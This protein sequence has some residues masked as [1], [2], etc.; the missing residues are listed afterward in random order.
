MEIIEADS[1]GALEWNKFIRQHYPPIGGFMLTYEWGEFQK[2]LGRNIKRYLITNQK[3]ETMAAFTA[4]QHS[5][6]L[7]FSYG[8][9]PRGP[10]INKE[11]KNEQV[12]EILKSI[13]DFAKESMVEL[14]FLRLEPPLSFLPPKIEEAGFYLPNYY[15]QPRYNLAVKIDGS[16]E[17]I[18][19]TFHPSTRSNVHRA[20]NRGVTVKLKNSLSENDFQK[21]FL[22]IKETIKRNSGVNAYPSEKYFKSLM[23]AIVSGNASDSANN[24]SCGIF[25]GYQNEVPAGA[26]FVL[27][28]GETA[29]YLYGASFSNRL[30]SKVTTYL[31]FTAMKEA[32]KRGMKYYDLGGIDEKRWPTLTVFKRQFKGKE[33]AYIGNI[34]IKLRPLLYFTYNLSRKVRSL[35]S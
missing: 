4:V 12:L 23:A 22:M 9:V 11:A 33:F 21:F 16:E 5:L 30:N 1:K 10:V 7:G 25:Y 8:Y 26:H 31:H 14:I 6:P 20:E 24:L 18:L 2:A 19:T 3:G 15:V 34:D 28:F 13:K 29:T 17:E 32:K 35:F 27:F